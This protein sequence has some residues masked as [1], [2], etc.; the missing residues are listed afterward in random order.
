MENSIQNTNTEVQVDLASISQEDFL[1]AME[2]SESASLKKMEVLMD[3]TAEYV[4]LE[5]A[6]ESFRGVYIGFQE[7]NITDK[8][9]GE[10]KKLKAAR[11]IIDK[12]VRINAG[13]VLVSEIHRAGVPVGT[14]LEVTYVRKDGNTKIYSIKLIA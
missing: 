14:P 7:I 4:E 9:S 6:G 11:F 13:A 12:K 10:S 2:K 5:K 3:L 1:A 8:Q